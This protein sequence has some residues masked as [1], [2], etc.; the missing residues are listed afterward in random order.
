MF[1][2]R[3]WQ[4]AFGQ[5]RVSISGLVG[6]QGSWSTVQGS[7]SC[8]NCEYGSGSAGSRA[9]SEKRLKV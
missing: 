5:I 8:S 9:C 7:G 3:C 6:L 4:R 2:K 1:G